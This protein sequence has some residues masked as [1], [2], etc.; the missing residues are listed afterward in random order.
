MDK[1][2]GMIKGRVAG[3]PKVRR[4]IRQLSCENGLGLADVGRAGWG[5]LFDGAEGVDGGFE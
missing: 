2:G 5:E 4:K 1:R 3:D